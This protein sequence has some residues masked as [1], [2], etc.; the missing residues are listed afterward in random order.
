MPDPAKSVGDIDD[1]LS[2]IR[3]LVAEQPARIGSAR[4]AGT[5]GRRNRTTTAVWCSHPPFA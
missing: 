5:P 3:R 4:I 2:S 1:V